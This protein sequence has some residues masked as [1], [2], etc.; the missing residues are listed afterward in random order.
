MRPRLLRSN[1]GEQLF[2]ASNT[3]ITT[4]QMLESGRRSSPTRFARRNSKLFPSELGDK[5]RYH[6]EPL[7]SLQTNEHNTFEGY[8]GA[9]FSSNVHP[10]QPYPQNRG[11]FQDHNI[12]STTQP[13]CLNTTTDTSSESSGSPMQTG[14][15]HPSH[16]SDETVKSRT[17][18]TFQELST[19]TSSSNKKSKQ[20]WS[21]AKT[22]RSKT[23]AS[24]REQ[25][26]CPPELSNGGQFKTSSATSTA[27]SSVQDLNYLV[28]SASSSS[29]A[30]K[31]SSASSFGRWFHKKGVPDMRMIKYAKEQRQLSRKRKALEA[32]EAQA[33]P[34][35]RISTFRH[36]VDTNSTYTSPEEQPSE[37]STRIPPSRSKSMPTKKS[38]SH[39]ER[40]KLFRAFGKH[41]GRS[42][43]RST[44][45][46][47]TEDPLATINSLMVKQP[48]TPST[49][50]TLSPARISNTPGS[51]STPKSSRFRLSRNASDQV[52]KAAIESANLARSRRTEVPTEKFGQA[53][54]VSPVAIKDGWFK[55]RRPIL[56]YLQSS[57]HSP[58]DNSNKAM[59]RPIIRRYQSS[60]LL[61]P[62]KLPPSMRDFLPTEAMRVN[63]P[64]PVK[65]KSGSG[66][67]FT[68][69]FHDFR[70]SEDSP[71]NPSPEMEYRAP[72]PQQSMQPSDLDEDF[73]PNLQDPERDWYRVRIDQIMD[74]DGTKDVTD[75]NQARSFEWDVPEHLPGSP[76]CPLSPKHRS[77]GKG[78]CVYH[79]RKADLG[80]TKSTRDYGA[81]S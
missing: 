51:P 30:T 34:S 16:A 57:G 17:S 69:Y 36:E 40:P 18:P 78:I 80:N 33:I 20:G 38:S 81:G 76:L 39:I 32:R 15:K 13:L 56:N 8:Y 75:L 41:S 71:L 24:T 4:S 26:N 77:G 59:K 49:P 50:E 12:S 23:T 67:R 10:D 66:K 44:P 54:E 7:M 1:S 58:T 27:K 43:Q 3:H 55:P 62:S 37:E 21:S 63:T 9:P 11:Y 61:S 79:G 22:S 6:Q 29:G 46:V 31:A 48:N 35:P 53:H 45:E 60:P 68:G 42:S 74:D 70:Y 25:N 73:E 19:T 5:R 2:K 14:E 47:Q 64:P 52:P 65:S 72:F 28:T